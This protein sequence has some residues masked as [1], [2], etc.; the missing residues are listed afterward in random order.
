MVI[1]FIDSELG[2]IILPLFLVYTSINS[3]PNN[4]IGGQIPDFTGCPQLRSLSLRNN[5]L[6]SY[7][8]GAFAKLYRI[9]FIDL[10]FNNLTQTDLDNIL[11]DLH[12]N[13]KDVKRGGVSVNLKNQINNG[14]IVFPTEAG[15]AKARI[16]VANGWSIGLSG[17]IPEEPPIIA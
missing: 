5:E 9:N 7:K 3:A 8:V 6:T 10:K 17:G 12:S 1:I 11:I 4:N 14:A 13:W 2:S 15:Y 16:L